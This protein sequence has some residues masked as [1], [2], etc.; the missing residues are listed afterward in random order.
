MRNYSCHTVNSIINTFE[1]SV[2]Y[3]FKQIYDELKSDMFDM[4]NVRSFKIHERE[5]TINVWGKATLLC[6]LS[7]ELSKA[8][9]FRN[10]IKYSF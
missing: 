5:K 1:K 6:I 8:F 3:P 9:D 7:I 4:S 2:N 10:L